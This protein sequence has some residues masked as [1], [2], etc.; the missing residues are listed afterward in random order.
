MVSSSISPTASAINVQNELNNYS[1]SLNYNNYFIESNSPTF[2]KIVNNKE[3]LLE[4]SNETKNEF[5]SGENKNSKKTEMNIQD[6]SNLIFSNVKNSRSWTQWWEANLWI[7]FTLKE[8][9][10][11][12]TLLS[13][14]K[15]FSSKFK[16]FSDLLYS[17]FDGS[18]KLVDATSGSL[19]EYFAQ[20]LSVILY[21]ASGIFSI[22]NEFSNYWYVKSLADKGNGV[23]S[24]MLL[25][26]F[27]PLGL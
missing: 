22:I 19:L 26:G 18:T 27:I 7:N 25:F 13:K 4:L 8:T 23:V 24:L 6:L 3:K 9:Q 20:A 12:L 14:F 1:N 10:T 11:Y 5:S 15:D 2:Q 21:I 16:N 17:V